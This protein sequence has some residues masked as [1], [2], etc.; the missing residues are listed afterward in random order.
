MNGIN[1]V[2]STNQ[3]SSVISSNF[4]L[5]NA[6]LIPTA[7]LNE[8]NLAQYREALETKLGITKKQFEITE[9]FV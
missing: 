7:T 5:K 2:L 9:A 1:S 4:K 8:E 6:Y 3:H